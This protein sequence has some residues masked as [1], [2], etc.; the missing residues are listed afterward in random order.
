MSRR[1]TERE[2]LDILTCLTEA[3]RRDAEMAETIHLLADL[4]TYLTA[5]AQR[6]EDLAAALRR[7]DVVLS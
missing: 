1:L 5:R 4:K 3:A 6:L 7:A 2:R